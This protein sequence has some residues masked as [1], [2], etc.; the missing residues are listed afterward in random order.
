MLHDVASAYSFRFVFLPTLP[1]STLI[2]LMFPIDSRMYH[3]DPAA[4]LAT[5]AREAWASPSHPGPTLQERGTH[6]V[7][8]D[9]V[10]NFFYLNSI[11]LSYFPTPDW[12]NLSCSSFSLNSYYV[13]LQTVL[14]DL[15]GEGVRDP[16][17]KRQCVWDPALLPHGVWSGAS[18]LWQPAH[19]AF[20]SPATPTEGCCSGLPCA[21]AQW[22]HPHHQVRGWGGDGYYV[23]WSDWDR[24]GYSHLEILGDVCVLPCSGHAGM[25][26]DWIWFS[27]PGESEP[28]SAIHPV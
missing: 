16:T 18:P 15:G 10:G 2:L 8:G 9:L 27:F 24:G 21:W 17:N 4:L 1:S 26:W 19:P 23:P 5:Q 3:T 7:H 12:H 14:K 13:L 25:T 20:S 6:P 28:Y 22:L 11:V